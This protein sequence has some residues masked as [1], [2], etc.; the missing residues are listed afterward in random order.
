MVDEMEGAMQQAAH[1]MRHCI[2]PLQGQI[3]PPPTGHMTFEEVEVPKAG[4]SQHGSGKLG[5]RAMLA[6]QYHLGSFVLRQSG[7]FEKNRH[8]R[9]MDGSWN[10][11]GTIFKAATHIYDAG[12]LPRF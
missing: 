3:D 4:D 1:P 7:K 10:M 2:L 6:G 9:N 5:T 11:A 8:E 12:S